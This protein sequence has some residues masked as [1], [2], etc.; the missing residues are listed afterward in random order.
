MRSLQNLRNSVGRT[1]LILQGGKSLLGIICRETFAD[2][3]R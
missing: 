1:A 2:Y 3:T